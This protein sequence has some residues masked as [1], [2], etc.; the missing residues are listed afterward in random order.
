MKTI[1]KIMF[2][3]LLIA[4]ILTACKGPAGPPGKDGKDGQDGQDGNA[5][6]QTYIFDVSSNSGSMITL[7]LNAITQ[8]VLEND[9]IL[10]YYKASN[11]IYYVAPG[12]GPDGNYITRVYSDV[13][14]HVIKFHNWNGTPYSI[15]AGDILLVKVIIIESTNTTSSREANRMKMLDELENAGVDINNYY[16]VCEYLGIDPE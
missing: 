15:S 2:F 12:P 10:T 6:V 14:M 1:S 11:D 13:G 16:A 8:D 9:A 3:T 7:N 4:G 5:N